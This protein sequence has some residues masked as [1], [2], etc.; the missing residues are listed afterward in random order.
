MAS[1]VS[2]RQLGVVAPSAPI[3][4]GVGTELP[5]L[6]AA[7]GAGWASVELGMMARDASAVAQ[8]REPGRAAQKGE[9]R[10]VRRKA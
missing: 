3:A 4:L 5:L 10:E 1:R 9:R 7:A 8:V 6:L 2:R